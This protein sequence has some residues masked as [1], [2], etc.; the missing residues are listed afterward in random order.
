MSLSGERL[1]VAAMVNHVEEGDSFENEPHMSYGRWFTVA[2]HRRHFL[3]NAM[4]NLFLDQPVLEEAVGGKKSLF[5]REGKPVFVRRI[6]GLKEIS[7]DNPANPEWYGLH[8][9]I[10]GIGEFD[11]NDKYNHA[12]RPHVTNTEEFRLQ[13][14][15]PV[16]FESVALIARPKLH[17]SGRVIANFALGRS[18]D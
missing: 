1:L 9:L 17:Q 3:L 8:S 6:Q 15:E 10:S 14:G 13:K 4:R 12:F 7:R 18:D 2:E 11:S 5:F 16:E